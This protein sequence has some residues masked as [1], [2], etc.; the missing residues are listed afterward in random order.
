MNSARAET[1]GQ[2]RER[3]AAIQHTDRVEQSPKSGGSNQ[4]PSLSHGAFF[5]SALRT[6][7]PNLT[8]RINAIGFRNGGSKRGQRADKQ[9]GYQ[10]G[11]VHADGRVE[12]RLTATERRDLFCKWRPELKSGARLGD[13][14]RHKLTDMMGSPH[15]WTD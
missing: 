3:E 1:G 5:T 8:T 15:R 10:R 14:R 6:N 13:N 11:Q 12:G 2:Q 9:W 7:L 4:V